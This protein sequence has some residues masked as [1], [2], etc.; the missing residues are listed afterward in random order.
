MNSYDQSGAFLHFWYLEML[1]ILRFKLAKRG[2]EIFEGVEVSELRD[3]SSSDSFPLNTFSC[4][5]NA[6]SKPKKQK[7]SQ[8]LFV[9][10]FLSLLA[11]IFLLK[12]NFLFSL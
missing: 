7:L 8:S 10:S 3:H 1:R 4:L 9:P 2:K 5:P 11:I 6:A 12:P